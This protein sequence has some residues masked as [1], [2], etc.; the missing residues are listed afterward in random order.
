MSKPVEHIMISYNT[1]TRDLCLKI[2]KELENSGQEVWMDVD[3]ICGS[4]YES[5]AEAVEKSKC[6]LMC[7]TES[8]RLSENCAMV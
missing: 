2:K 1:K 3:K 4:S 6:I 8:Y 5:M 7:F